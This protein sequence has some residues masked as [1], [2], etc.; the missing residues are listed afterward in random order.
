MPLSG[1]RKPSTGIPASDLASAVSGRLTGVSAPPYLGNAAY[2]ESFSAWIGSTNITIQASGIANLIGI[3]LYAGDAITS[4]T[5]ISGATALTMGS[6]ADGHMWFALYDPAGNLLAQTADQG[7]AATWASNTVKTL[8]LTSP[9]TI[10]ASGYH[11]A[12]LMVNSG[13]GGSPTVPSMRGTA[14]ASTAFSTT[15]GWPA[16][17]KVIVGSNG[18]SLGGTAPAGPITP[19]AITNAPY[20]VAT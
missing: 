8:A 14:I 13:T 18:S 19:T 3:S 5:F 11:Y 16:G 17:R 7:G 12:A 15:T 10:A 2:R 4:L 1:Y 20:V 9:Q 6:N